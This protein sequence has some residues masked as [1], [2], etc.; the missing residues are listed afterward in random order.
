MTFGKDVRWEWATLAFVLLVLYCVP[1]VWIVAAIIVGY[2]NWSVWPVLAW[3]AVSIVFLS[4]QLYKELNR[5]I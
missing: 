5:S 1:T 2:I 3:S 4:W